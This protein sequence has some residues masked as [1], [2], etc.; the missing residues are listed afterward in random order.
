[1]TTPKLT[2]AQRLALR[3][4]CC[5][6]GTPVRITLQTEDYLVAAGYIEL[7]DQIDHVEYVPT[8]AGLAAAVRR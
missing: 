8:E 5:P 7:R 1:M 4:I 2:E 6:Q 3:F